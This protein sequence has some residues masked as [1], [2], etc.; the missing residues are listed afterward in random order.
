MNAEH[1]DWLK[2]FALY[3]AGYADSRCDNYAQVVG[4]YDACSAEAACRTMD[5]MAAAG[6][7]SEELDVFLSSIEDDYDWIR[8]GC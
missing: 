6:A 1:S 7:T 2:G 4:W 5:Y 3:A 8:T